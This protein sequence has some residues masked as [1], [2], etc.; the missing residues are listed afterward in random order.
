MPKN[1]AYNLEFIQNLLYWD[2]MKPVKT[3]NTLLSLISLRQKKE[4]QITI[5]YTIT[6]TEKHLNS[7]RMPCN[8]ILKAF[9]TCER[10]LP[11]ISKMRLQCYFAPILLL[12]QKL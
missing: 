6:V 11:L 5:F 4:K 8:Y 12:V 9:K 10:I 1:N 2:M 7:R 3:Q